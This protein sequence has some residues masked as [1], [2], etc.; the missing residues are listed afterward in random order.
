LA[1]DNCGNWSGYVYHGSITTSPPP[2]T[3]A[4]ASCP[5]PGTSATISWT[6]AAGYTTHYLRG[7]NTALGWP[8]SSWWVY[9]DNYVG[10]SY[11]AAS[12]AGATYSWWVHTKNA[13][14]CY[15]VAIGT[16]FTCGVPPFDFSM[17]VSPSSGSVSQG[18]STTATATATLTS[19][20]TQAVTFSASGLPS[21]ANAGFSPI[22]CNPTCGSTMTITTQ[23][24][25]PAGTYPIT[26]TGTA[27]SLI[28]TTTYT[29]TVNAA[30][31]SVT[32]TA[33]PSSGT[34]PLTG[35]VLR[36]TVAGTATGTINYTFYCDRS[37]T[38]TNVTLPYSHKLD[39]TNTNPY[40]APATTCDSVYTTA[41]TYT[42]KVIVERGGL[43]R[44]SRVSV[45]V[46][47]NVPTADTFNS[48]FSNWC[49]PNV[50]CFFS[51]RYFDSDGDAESR[52][53]FQVDT[54]SSFNLPRIVDRTYPGLN[55]PS[56]TVNNQQISV[57]PPPPSTE[58][59]TYGTTYYWRVRV[60]DSQGADSGWLPQPPLVITAIHRYPICNFTWLPKY[61]N[62]TEDVQF[63]D[64]STCFDDNPSGSDCS[65]ATGDS[66]IWTITNGNPAGSVLENPLSIFS[67]FG[68]SNVT[69]TVTDS[70][71][72]SCSNTQSIN[73]NFPLPRWKE[74]KP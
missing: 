62:P 29:L 56:G 53:D 33:T 55:N 14:S 43:A 52:F 60:W 11:T 65:S 16:N 2:P 63:T 9:N 54:D 64:T 31:L 71:G 1:K 37:D 41:G 73:I 10:N 19:G 47:N 22:S 24:S 21:G 35:V 39:G 50:A 48:S 36:A 28:R 70:D 13:L 12:T 17:S 40:S 59:M 7:Y 3:N 6:P 68:N 69:L 8:P 20:T 51:W 30:T 42:A 5:A 49:L 72:Y 58:Q 61:P 34:A 18:G 32:L 4:Q 26:I 66:F 74:I 45:T 27:G 57:V 46:N 15:S 23:S 25:T 67:S 44:E 38:G